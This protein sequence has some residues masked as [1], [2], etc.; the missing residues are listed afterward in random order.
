MYLGLGGLKINY[1]EYGKNN[2]K[3]ILFIHGLGSS[4]TSWRD[5]PQALSE[6]FHTITVD[7]IGFG[8]SDKPEVDYTITYFSQFIKNFLQTIIGVDYEE[9]K[10]KIILIGH[11]LG[12]YIA[13]DFTLENKKHVEKLI[14]IDPSGMLDGPT[15][16]LRFYLDAATETDP[17]LRYKKINRVFEDMTAERSRLLPIVI[18]IFIGTIGKP[19]AKYAFES[20][21]YNSTK[22]HIDSNR[23]NQIKD[24]P[25]LIIWGEKD[26]LIPLYYASK[27]KEALPEFQFDLISDA[28]HSPHAEKPYIVYEKIRTFLNKNNEIQ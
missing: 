2:K 21:F 9:A 4:S 5:L 24:I 23:L 3:H 6:H 28:G 12:G 11:S 8:E 15:P 19:G 22:T 17:I 14:L 20:T 27:F 16:L 10:E 26:N 1:E 18:D 7:L 25:S 13:I